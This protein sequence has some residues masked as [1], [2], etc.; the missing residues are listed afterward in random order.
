KA[1]LYLHD[2]LSLC[3]FLNHKPSTEITR[4]D[5]LGYL[6]TIRKPLS[7]EP[8]QRWINTHSNRAVIYLKF[9][10]W[11]YFPDLSLK[12]RLTTAAVKD[13]PIMKREETNVQAVDL[14]TDDDAYSIFL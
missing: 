5:I 6:A 4:D 13:L 12:E 14:W 9:C 7:A 3:R 10:K 2:Y 8:K 1:R 11:L